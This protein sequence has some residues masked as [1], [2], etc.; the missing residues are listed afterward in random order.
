MAPTS[1]RKRGP[2]TGPSLV[3]RRKTGS[4]HHLICGGRGSSLKVITTAVN[5][6]DI[7]QTLALVD[8]IPG[9]PCRRP[10]GLL[11]DK[12]YDSKANRRQLGKRRILPSFPAEEHRTCRAWA[13]SATSWSR[14]SP[15]STT[16]NAS[17][18]AGNAA[19]NCTTHSYPSPAHSSAGDA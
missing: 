17:P 3:D 9:R 15:C 8:G 4:K 13:N 18:S 10:D 2:D 5:V 6:N 11:G 14:A 7:T 19:P 12:G 16:S 1:A